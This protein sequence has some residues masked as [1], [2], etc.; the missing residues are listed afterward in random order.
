M[1]PNRKE[2]VMNRKVKLGTVVVAVVMVLCTGQVAVAQVD[3]TWDQ[4]VVPPAAPGSRH[5]LGDVVFDGTTW[6]MYL[7]GGLGTTPINNPWTVGHWVWN[8]LTLVWDEDLANNPVLQAESGQWDGFGIGGIAVLYHGGMFHM[9]YSS[10]AAHLA[11]S[12]VGYA[13]SPDGSNWTKDPNNP[14]AGLGPGSPGAWD[15]FGTSPKTVFVEGSTHY[16]WYTA[17]QGS[18]SVGTWRIGHAHSTDGGLTWTKETSWVLEGSEPWEGNKVF[19]PTVV[20]S[21]DR[22]A[23]WYGGSDGG[24]SALGY[25][26]STDGL[27]WTRWPAN[28]VLRPLPGCDFVD[29]SAVIFDGDTARGWVSNCSD[30]YH[31]TAPMVLFADDFETGDTSI[32]SLTVPIP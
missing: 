23:M 10:A 12:F 20:R 6:H 11:P 5:L 4:L 17:F 25:A 29:S 2:L 24:I 31:V 7:I 1:N 28:P 26:E 30:V 8:D 9:W 3:W 19:F 21:G 16:M 32:W 14:L 15:D 13:T 18:Y 27:V 22:L